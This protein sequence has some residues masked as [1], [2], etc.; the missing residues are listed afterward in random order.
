MAQIVIVNCI[1]CGYEKLVDASKNNV[2]RYKTA[3]P[4]C[5]PCSKVGFSNSGTFKRGQTAW[6]KGTR[7]VMKQ[8]ATSFKRGQHLSPETEFK[9]GQAPWNKGKLLPYITGENHP[10]WKGDDVGYQAL[11]SWVRRRLGTPRKCANCGIL[12]LNRYEW[13]NISHDYNRDISDWI[14]LCAKCHR[15]YDRGNIFIGSNH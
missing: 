4:R 10:L 3:H 12:G 1:D 5:N 15:N 11:H 14:R 7:G 6:N 13:A 9:R 8:N 2:E